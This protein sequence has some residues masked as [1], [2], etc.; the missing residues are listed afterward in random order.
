MT[1]RLSYF[2]EP[3]PDELL[4]SVLA[5]WMRH[6][7]I[8]SPGLAA[9]MLF[10]DR[11]AMATWDLPGRIGDLCE[12]LPD[13]PD[14]NGLIAVA[15]LAPYYT[16]FASEE[17]RTWVVASMSGGTADLHM[18]LGLTAS[19]IPRPRAPRH[20]LHCDAEAVVRHGERYWRRSHQLPGVLVCPM[21]AVPLYE[22]PVLLDRLGRHGYLAADAASCPVGGSRRCCAGDDVSM[23]LLLEIARR[24]ADL[25][26]RPPPPTRDGDVARRYRELA[27]RGGLMRSPARV[28]VA[29][30]RSGFL[31]RVG[32]VLRDLPV[33]HPSIG[34]G[35]GWLVALTRRQR[36]AV[37]PLL[38][39]LATLHLEALPAVADP[40]PPH[41]P[42]FGS[43][44]WPCL[45]PLSEHFGEAVVR[46]VSHY[47]N[48]DAVV[49]VF[50]CSCGYRYTRGVDRRGDLGPPRFRSY[51]P[52]LRPAVVD[53]LAEGTTLR[54]I[55]ARV[56]LDPK[57]VVTEMHAMG[58]ETP[59]RCGRPRRAGKPRLRTPRRGRRPARARIDW[60]GRDREEVVKVGHAAAVLLLQDPP[61]RVTPAA[62][63]RHLGRR[64]W[65]RH[66]RSKLPLANAAL[67]GHEEALASFQRRRLQWAATALLASGDDPTPWRALRIAGLRSEWLA[68]AAALL[69]TTPSASAFI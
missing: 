68:E 26:D 37:H 14:P 57:T 18:R 36:K 30:M 56:G 10:G 49:G 63:E 5:R 4:H 12:R 44:P 42:A 59:W 3:Y 39:V 23:P 50:A 11:R 38:H 33:A 58:I 66:R 69:A 67:D 65:L 13:C 47:R 9:E 52:L 64:G 27:R 35:D 60:T 2:P 19:R 53:A 22:S 31:D 62:I 61:V 43:G 32:P 51:G 21:H 45:N 8:D 25:L 34:G 6:A 15:T 20:C 28:D 55:A 17:T 54:S 29:R 48:R 16:A 40:L 46:S 24:S 41:P 7:R 1:R